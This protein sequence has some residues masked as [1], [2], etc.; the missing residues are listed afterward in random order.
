MGKWD[1]NIW[2]WQLSWTAA[3]GE[4]LLEEIKQIKDTLERQNGSTFSWFFFS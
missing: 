3:E 2:T 4:L 1:N